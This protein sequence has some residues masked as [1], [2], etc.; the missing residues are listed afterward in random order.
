MSILIFFVV[1]LTLVIVHEFGHFIAAKKFGMRVDEFGFGFPPKAFAKKFGETLYS[2]N[3]LPIGGFVKIYG[4]DALLEGEDGRT[5]KAPDYERSFIAKPRW[6]QAIVLFAGVA[7]NFLLAWILFT[8]VYT[9]GF[10]DVIPEA[11]AGEGAVTTVLSV[12]PDGPAARAGIPRGAEI[13]SINTANIAY[14]NPSPSNFTEFTAKHAN[15]GALTMTYQFEGEKKTVRVTTETGLIAEEPERRLMGISLGYVI[16]KSYPAHIA[17]VKALETSTDM[18]VKITFGLGTFFADLVRGEANISQMAG[19]VGL[20]G[21]VGEASQDG[22]ITLLRLT[23]F[24]SLNLV[25]INLFPF[26]ALDGGRLVFVAIEAIRRKAMPAK[27]VMYANAAGFLLLI[28]LM[29]AVT[30][31]DVSKLL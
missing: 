9:T 13:L 4:E 31:S 28:G 23:A 11:E 27:F 22:I 12:L 14:P 16:V 20:V 18:L 8:V 10:K 1:L 26:P 29:V 3:I 19:P 21:I 30:I 17:V 7:M 25:V 5:E 6:A 15:E 2:F 24:I